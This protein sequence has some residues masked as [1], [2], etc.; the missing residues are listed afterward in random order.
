M[1]NNRSPWPATLIV[2]GVL[3]RLVTINGGPATRLHSRPTLVGDDEQEIE[4]MY[5][6]L[7]SYHQKRSATAAA[8]REPRTDGEA[9][10]GD[11]PRFHYEVHHVTH[12]FGHRTPADVKLR[13][14]ARHAAS[15]SVNDDDD[16]DTAAGGGGGG[17]VTRPRPPH[18][19]QQSDELRDTADNEYYDE[20]SKREERG[21]VE[22]L[23]HVADQ[24]DY[25]SDNSPSSVSDVYFV[26]VVVGCSVAGLAG[27]M[28][29]AGCWYRL[30]KKM[31]AT[32]EVSYPA[33]GVTGP[34]GSPTGKDDS[35]GD[36]KLAQSAQMY[37]YQ[38]QKQQMIASERIN[39]EQASG[40][41]D[42][43]S[44]VES[45]DDNDDADYTVFECRGLATNGEMEVRNPLFSD[46]QTSGT[47]VTDSSGSAPGPAPA[48][49]ATASQA[50][51]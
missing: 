18:D 45:E 31:K 27:L 47:A 29:A 25:S 51:K 20:E 8:R 35:P 41:V 13:Q 19:N 17:H 46:Q 39:Q 32:S 24:F 11:V 36:R 12:Q 50:K 43:R 16:D 30:H 1:S 22:P 7:D 26:A 28:M 42:A 34:A 9:H 14:V 5:E 23:A 48:G 38:H 3:S 21:R 33:Y 2:F 10:A 4:R 15:T 37:H 40:R 49:S 44:D 6:M